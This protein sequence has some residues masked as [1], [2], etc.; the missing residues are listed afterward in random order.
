VRAR[1]GELASAACAVALAVCM[2]AFAWY[3]VD[4]IP[5][6]PAARGGVGKTEDAWHALPVVRWLMLFTVLSAVA[7]A[8]APWLRKRVGAHVR[9]VWITLLGCL[10]AALLVFRVLIDLPSAAAVPDQ[11]LGALLGMASALGIPLG[12]WEALRQARERSRLARAQERLARRAR[13]DGALGSAAR[14]GGS[15]PPTLG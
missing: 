4:E 13:V 7:A 15:R 1:S 5:G 2:F 6:R 10:T 9:A 14:R 11:K 8:T 12:G 3:G